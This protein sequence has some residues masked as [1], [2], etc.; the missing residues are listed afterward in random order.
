MYHE[1]GEQ[2]IADSDHS[3]LEMDA[4]S[5][6]A[7]YVINH[8]N[9]P[10]I[11]Q[12]G[13]LSHDK[14]RGGF[15]SSDGRVHVSKDASYVKCFPY[16]W[17]AMGPYVLSLDSMTTS[18]TPTISQGEQ[19]QSGMSLPPAVAVP[20]IPAPSTS[21]VSVDSKM[22]L[23]VRNL[24]PDEIPALVSRLTGQCDVVYLCRA[25]GLDLK[26][27]DKVTDG[28]FIRTFADNL[29]TP[30]DGWRMLYIYDHHGV[31]VRAN[32]LFQGSMFELKVF[33]FTNRPGLYPFLFKPEHPG[34]WFNTV[35]GRAPWDDIVLD[36]RINDILTGF[37]PANAWLNDAGDVAKIDWEIIRWHT[38]FY[39]WHSNDWLESR[40]SFAAALH[41]VSVAKKHGITV[42]ILDA[43]SNNVM[44]SPNIAQQ[45]H[46]FNLAVP[47]NLDATSTFN[48]ELFNY[49]YFN[50]QG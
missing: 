36:T 30:F 42:D 5:R 35:D 28:N 31:F 1:G 16:P 7:I 18:Y 14:L 40:N 45:A 26:D 21:T 10:L 8:A 24:S 19:P 17:Q 25:L 43:A 20:S 23:S 29:T 38:V 48:K 32:V 49:E 6:L 15:N 3:V 50:Q 13:D 39:A 34:V 33:K 27:F 46:G 22:I 4:A 41:F 9:S 47:Q 2:M 12:C 37:S 44:D 11:A